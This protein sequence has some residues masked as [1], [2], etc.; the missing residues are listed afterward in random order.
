MLDKEV[1]ITHLKYTRGHPVIIE[2]RFLVEL[3]E[4][5]DTEQLTTTTA[6]I[7][8]RWVSYQCE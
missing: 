8:Y 6:K 5:K 3:N 1:I 2:D 4:K 7:I